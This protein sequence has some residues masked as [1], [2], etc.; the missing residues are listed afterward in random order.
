MSKA[1]LKRKELTRVAYGKG[2]SRVGEITF[3]CFA[4]WCTWANYT[5]KLI[6]PFESDLL[7]YYCNTLQFLGILCVII[8]SSLFPSVI[9]GFLI[10]YAF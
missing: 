8:V 2:G 3:H 1:T 5:W 9:C 4:R 10:L 7:V 6:M